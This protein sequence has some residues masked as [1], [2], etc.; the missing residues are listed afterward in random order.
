MHITGGRRVVFSCNLPA[1][2]CTFPKTS[3]SFQN[4]SST[5]PQLFF[6]NKKFIFNFTPDKLF[7]Q[8]SSLR[9]EGYI[10]DILWQHFKVVAGLLPPIITYIPISYT[11][12]CTIA[13]L[14]V[15]SL[16]LCQFRGKSI[17]HFKRKPYYMSFRR[18]KGGRISYTS[19]LCYQDSS[20]TL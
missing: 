13:R 11:P 12:C 18:P 9:G 1:T 15:K 6:N 14:S 16:V 2:N 5:L 4:S 7:V 20:L 10:K 19:T 17:I 8:A 3:A